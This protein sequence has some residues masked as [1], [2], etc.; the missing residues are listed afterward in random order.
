[1][2]NPLLTLFISLFFSFFSFWCAIGWS[3]SFVPQ[4]YKPHQLSGST[5]EFLCRVRPKLSGVWGLSFYVQTLGEFSSLK[6]F[7][8]QSVSGVSTANITQ[9]SN[10][11]AC[12]LTP[13]AANV[14]SGAE[15]AWF[16]EDGNFNLPSII[17]PIITPFTA[18]SL[19][20]ESREGAERLKRRASCTLCP[21]L[22][23]LEQKRRG[24]CLYIIRGS[25]IKLL[26]HSP[27]SLPLPF[28][29][30]FS[31]QVAG[32]LPWWL[33]SITCDS[34]DLMSPS[35]SLYLFEQLRGNCVTL[36]VE[37]VLW[38][39]TRWTEGTRRGSVAIINE[40]YFPQHSQTVCMCVS[41][42]VCVAGGV[43]VFSW[44]GGQEGVM[45]PSTRG[46]FNCE[47]H[48]EVACTH[49]YHHFLRSEQNCFCACLL[50]CSVKDEFRCCSEELLSPRSVDRWCDVFHA[51]F[52]SCPTDFYSMLSPE[53]LIVN[54]FNI[55]QLQLLMKIPS[56]WF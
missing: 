40:G 3:A 21:T 38:R 4:P 32:G 9:A 29:P 23:W 12:D 53:A 13:L 44:W 16:R 52:E 46:E 17:F 31:W 54:I 45:S 55:K 27:S 48:I 41:V 1:M 35:G 34:F 10:S 42:C 33:D 20:P 47:M 28:I 22:I 51:A 39:R 30:A 2:L 24:G 56:P 6:C 43:C 26:S 11:H 49:S 14:F 25:I 19:H 36:A 8:F 15:P 5:C 37:D 50:F 7:F 18:I